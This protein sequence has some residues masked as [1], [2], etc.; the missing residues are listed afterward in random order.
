M[1]LHGNNFDFDWKILAVQP[2]R[3]FVIILFTFLFEVK[4]DSN[5]FWKKESAWLQISLTHQVLA[6]QSLKQ[7]GFYI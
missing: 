5:V 3:N 4:K 1:A 2:Q 6:V 7:K